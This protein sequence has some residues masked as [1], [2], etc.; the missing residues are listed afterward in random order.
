M[1]AIKCSSFLAILALAT[2]TQLQSQQPAAPQSYQVINY[3]KVPASGRI[4]FEELMK[5]TSIKTAETRLNA[6]EIVSWTLLRAVMPAGEKARSDYLISTIYESVPP[7]PLDR[8]GT[9]AL[10]KKAG[11][12]MPVDDFF[13]K[14]SR[15]SSLVNTELWRPMSRVGA[16][17][18]GHYIYLNQMK[19]ADA[20]AYLEFEQTVWRPIAERLVKDGAISGWMSAAKM[21]PDG[22]ETGYRFYTVDMY[23]S[24]AALFKPGALRTVF[25]QVHAGKNFE[26]TMGQ[27]EKL[28]TIAVRELWVVVER[29]AK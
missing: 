15:L 24:W 22:S 11:V 13:A 5:E 26:E 6:G 23:P 2:V 20:D 9:A 10:F 29:V 27:M 12:L 14:R 19:T 1:K 21:L 28:R 18:K 4:E 8:T 16:L 7:E 3:I 25:E 17:K